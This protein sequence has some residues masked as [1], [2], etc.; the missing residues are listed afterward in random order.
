MS[1]LIDVAHIFD[2]KGHSMASYEELERQ[3][4][5]ARTRIATLEHHLVALHRKNQAL[6]GASEQRAIH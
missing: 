5:D 3:L 1:R 4:T 6:A 2:A